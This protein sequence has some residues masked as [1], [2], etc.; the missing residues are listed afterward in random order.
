MPNYYHEGLG[1]VFWSEFKKFSN[2]GRLV[3]RIGVYPGTFDPITNGHM[4]VISRAMR[5]VDR[6]VVGVTTSVDKQSLLT[7][8]KRVMLT[9]DE[10]ADLPNDLSNRIDVQPFDGLL[11]DFVVNC[12]A[13][14]VIRGLRAISDFE[15]EFQMAG[16]NAHLNPNIETIFLMASERNQFIS[17]RFV[18]EIGRLGGDIQ[19]FASSRVSMALCEHFETES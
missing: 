4:D 12:G 15:F 7:L 5:V 8:D 3:M 18:K 2:G 17:S 14:M 9:A 11:I 16:M 19:Q 6:L 1:S 10:I 13:Q